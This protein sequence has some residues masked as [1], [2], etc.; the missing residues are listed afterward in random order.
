[1]DVEPGQSHDCNHA[2]SHYSQHLAAHSFS[3][4]GSQKE[5]RRGG[6]ARPESDIRL[7]PALYYYYGYNSTRA[8][9]Q[10]VH[11]IWVDAVV[12][13]RRATRQ[14]THASF[15]MPNTELAIMRC[16]TE[17]LLAFN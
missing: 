2:C 9:L 13:F 12:R 4:Q 14:A 7:L 16:W 5:A 11:A 3:G 10:N 1:M 6:H 8:T 15:R 17:L